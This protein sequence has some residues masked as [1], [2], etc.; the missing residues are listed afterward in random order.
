VNVPGPD[1]GLVFA[2]VEEEALKLL[3]KQ[4]VWEFPVQALL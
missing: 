2:S 4:S 1:Q 3:E